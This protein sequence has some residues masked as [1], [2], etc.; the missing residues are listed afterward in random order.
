MTQKSSEKYDISL[1]YFGNVNTGAAK[2]SLR[3]HAWSH[4]CTSVDLD[5]GNVIVVVNGILTHDINITT[6]NFRD[7]VP[8]VFEKNLVLGLSHAKY[9][10]TP[11]EIRQSEVS[12]TNVNIFSAALSSSEMIRM[13]STGH[14]TSGDVLSWTE[15]AWNFTGIVE[16]LVLDGFCEKPYFPNLL[17]MAKTFD[18]FYDCAHLC[19]RL[20]DDGRIPLTINVSESVILAKQFKELAHDYTHDNAI[21]SS[22]I[23][24]SPNYFIDFYSKTEFV[25]EDMWIPGQPNGGK[26]QPC[27]IWEGNGELGNFYDIFCIDIARPQQCLCQFKE[28]PILKLRGLCKK[29]TIDSHFTL[30]YNQSDGS[31]TLIGLS[32]T[33]IK[34]STKSLLP[35]WQLTVN[36]KNTSGFSEKEEKSYVLGRNSWA[37]RNDSVECERGEPYKTV[38]KMSGCAEGFFTCNNGDCIKMEARCDQVLNCPDES[39]EIKC[40]TI[41]LKRSYRKTAPPVLV[42]EDD[43]VQKAS[44]R[45]TITLLD[46]AAFRETD[47]E[48]DIKF[49]T[50]LRWTDPRVTYHNLKAHGNTLEVNDISALW[51]P[52]LVFRNNKNN[53][54]TRSSWE[55]SSFRIVRNGTFTR[56]ELDVVDEIEIFKG[57]EN[58]LIMLQSFTKDFKCKFSLKV[59]PFDTQV[60]FISLEVDR[61][62]FWGV[63]L[64]PGEARIETDKELTEYFITDD[65]KSPTIHKN[66]ETDGI[67]LKLIF[68]RRLTN[69]AVMTFFPSLLL[70]IISYATS[71]F[72][73]PNF[74]NTAIT[75]NL[76][77]MLTI[78]TLLISVVKKLAKTSYIKWIEAWLIFAMLIPFT[79]VIL[80]TAIDLLQEEQVKEERK[81]KE[82][83]KDPALERSKEHVWLDVANNIVKVKLLQ[84]YH[85]GKINVF[86]RALK[87]GCC[88]GLH[89]RQFSKSLNF[90]ILELKTCIF[91]NKKKVY[92]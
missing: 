62:D 63:E 61:A 8:I 65:P 38:L 48:I 36:M 91:F 82:R 43:K 34:F 80:I 33:A 29:S 83:E 31:I 27:T 58:P 72:R 7:N 39:D 71:Y 49:A 90:L 73:L 35:K 19:S 4:A 59:F 13:S 5:T 56:S 78:T 28:P 22:F 26:S 45:V 46:I 2:V 12:V 69:E 55:Q 85:G 86:E 40:K 6:N 77:V 60:C 89:Q 24:K 87:I 76:T 10:G 53:D 70:I 14:C 18:N 66:N 51:I 81:T 88:E 21:W 52:K 84:N 47:N 54:H 64:T 42:T 16:T 79:L 67:D 75:V 41:V 3:P 37:I 20:K 15:A 68:K 57:I 44:I 23:Y 25:V 30:N 17:L 50:E 74:F 9:I 1:F 92:I 32:G 11:D